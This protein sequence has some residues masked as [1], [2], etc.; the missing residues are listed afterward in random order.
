MLTNKKKRV[1]IITI[2]QVGIIGYENALLE[3]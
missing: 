3:F 1:I 2:K